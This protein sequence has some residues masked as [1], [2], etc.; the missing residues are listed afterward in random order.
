MGEFVD[1]AD[2][3]L[4]AEHPSAIEGS[5]P[6]CLHRNI[7]G[8]T[9]HR[10]GTDLQQDRPAITV[11]QTGQDRRELRVTPWPIVIITARATYGEVVSVTGDAQR[12]IRLHQL[13]QLD[14]L[15][16]GLFLAGAGREFDSTP[17][18]CARTQL[19]AVGFVS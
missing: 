18:L 2:G 5:V 9:G 10:L 1:G 4:I 3:F 13:Q 14:Q 11:H 17:F 6:D 7:L 16:R 8:E 19:L 12:L 15:R